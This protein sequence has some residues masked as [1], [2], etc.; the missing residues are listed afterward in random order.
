MSYYDQKTA[1]SFPLWTKIRSDPS[2]Y[3]HRFYS[4]FSNLFESLQRDAVKLRDSFKIY[5]EDIGFGELYEIHLDEDDY[6]DREVNYGAETITYPSVVATDYDGNTRELTRIGSLDSFFYSI[7]EYLNE[8]NTIV[9]DDWIVWESSSPDT[10]LDIKT[11]ERLG[12]WVKNS[13]HYKRRTSLDEDLPFGGHHFIT[14]KGFDS[15][16]RVA[17][18]RLKILDDGLYRTSNIFEE[19][20]EVVWDGFDGDITITISTSIY[21]M[22]A[23]LTPRIID[24]FKIGAAPDVVGP[25]LLEIDTLDGASYLKSSV[26]RWLKGITYRRPD[27]DA[28]DDAAVEIISEQILRDVNGD[29]YAAVD[30]AVSPVDGR[31]YILDDHGI[32]HVYDHGLSEFKHE[33]IEELSDETYIDVI[34]LQHRVKLNDMIYL[35]TWFRV[36]QGI[37]QTVT[38]SRIDPNGNTEYLQADKV[39]WDTA[40]YEF[41]GDV[42]SGNP[43]GSWEDIRFE[44]NFP[45]TGQW[46]FY[47]EVK[48]WGVTNT[49]K[50]AAGVFCE[51][52]TSI[53]DMDTGISDPGGIFFTKD[54]L[55][56]IAKSGEY[57][58]FKL[59]NDCFI[60]DPVNNILF[61]REDYES[62]EVTYE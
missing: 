11:P 62:V 31:L 18:E 55:I 29:T 8:R 22:N 24:R 43:E 51:Q 17:I 25:L 12:I 39:T 40:I 5:S 48:F 50:S 59:C 4:S 36:L 54:C 49:F 53:S 10:Y 45:T 34:P 44:S 20:T 35:W 1:N 13:T 37:V 3:G 23:S 61:L 6:M 57:T 2:A 16:H 15:N 19:I 60:G 28:Y 32:I 14:I 38:I 30:M 58:T 41:A 9:V 27:G 52:L 42:T 47:C 26:L 21:P 46:M 56:G 7:P 33:N